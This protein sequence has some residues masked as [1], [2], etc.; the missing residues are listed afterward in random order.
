MPMVWQS[1]P[2]SSL[3]TIRVNTPSALRVQGADKAE[4]RRRAERW[5]DR[6]QVPECAERTVSLPSGVGRQSVA[7]AR[8]LVGEPGFPLADQLLRRLTP[9]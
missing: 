5:P 9:R 8:S 7:L 4:R 1:L 3:L 6:M 2:V